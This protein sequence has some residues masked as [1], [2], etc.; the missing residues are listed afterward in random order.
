MSHAVDFGPVAR[1]ASG[2]IAEYS[3]VKLEANNQVG[4]STA[5][6][7]V[8]D[9]HGVVMEIKGVAVGG[10]GFGAPAVA[11]DVID[12]NMHGIVRV[13]LGAT[14]AVGALCGA[15]AQGRAVTCAAGEFGIVQVL[16]AGVVNE[17]VYAKIVN[18]QA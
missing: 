6:A 13:M 8:T 5:R 14:V 9:A 4:Q 3:I 11:G 7:A 1:E 15:D 2:A 18:M 12:V 17:I 16:Q 10:S